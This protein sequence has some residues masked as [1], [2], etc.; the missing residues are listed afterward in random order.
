MRVP[1]APAARCQCGGC[2][3]EQVSCMQLMPQA[4][5]RLTAGDPVKNARALLRYALPIDNNSMRRIQVPALHAHAPMTGCRRA[6]CLAMQRAATILRKFCV[7]MAGGL[8]LS[9]TKAR[10]RT[11]AC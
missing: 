7:T 3:S 10:Q 2:L 11:P 4:E 9:S 5:A 1:G 8:L 6:G